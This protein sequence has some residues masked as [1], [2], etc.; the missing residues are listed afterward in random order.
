MTFAFQILISSAIFCVL[1]LVVLGIQKKGFLKHKAVTILL[2]TVT[3]LFFCA[4][5]F[6]CYSEFTAYEARK[7]QYAQDD[8]NAL[9]VMDN[10]VSNQGEL[11]AYKYFKSYRSS[12]NGYEFF[13][14]DMIRNSHQE[15]VSYI[16]N[17]HD[18][19]VEQ[20]ESEEYNQEY[21]DKV[22]SIVFQ[23]EDSTKTYLKSNYEVTSIIPPDDVYT[24]LNG[25]YGDL[26]HA[27]NFSYFE[28]LCNLIYIE[29]EIKNSENR[30]AA[31]IET[32]WQYNKAFIY[33][34]FSKSK[35]DQLCKQLVNDLITVHDR[36]VAQPDYK[37]F[38][39]AYDVSDGVFLDFPSKK[40]T[41]SFQFSWPFSFWD[42]R[43]SEHN[44]EQV[45]NILKEL[46]NHYNN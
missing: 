13:L 22:F 41:S 3:S 28:R 45:Y 11:D 29:G 17:L 2:L 38:Y 42:R 15:Q 14:I 30:S 6:F 37:A 33:T 1:I 27:E 39:E 4:S 20:F 24:E 25:D 34:F 18:K 26:N 35:Y 23:Q 9:D 43:F 5:L 36:I 7:K 44:S 16:Y 21:W 32:L 31:R 46:Q 8:K 10:I 12:L 40:F 19:I